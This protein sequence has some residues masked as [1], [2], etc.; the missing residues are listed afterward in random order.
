[1]RESSQ[2]D[3]VFRSGD[4][5]VGQLLG[6]CLLFLGSLLAV[7][8]E[9][10]EAGWVIAGLGG[11]LAWQGF[12][13]RKR[14]YARIGSEYLVVYEHG[15]VRHYIHLRSIKL[16]RRRFNRTVLTMQDGVEIAIGHSGFVGTE[17]AQRFRT[18][19]ERKIEE[20]RIT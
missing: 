2:P 15:G 16:M 18:A 11:L 8:S 6:I 1:M 17:D 12:R 20:E 3:D 5:L 19:L 10:P 9:Y 14:P 7:V 4:S 13:H